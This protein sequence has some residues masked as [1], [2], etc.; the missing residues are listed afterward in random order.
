MWHYIQIQRPNLIFL[1][2]ILKPYI[3]LNSITLS[4]VAKDLHSVARLLVDQFTYFGDRSGRT[5]WGM[6]CLRPLKHWGRRFESHLRH[7]CVCMFILC[8]GL[9]T[10]WSPVEEV[11]PTVHRIKKLKKGPRP[12]KRAVEQ[13][14]IIIIII[15]IYFGIISIF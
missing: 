10:S 8:C 14:I 6:N 15:I 3:K 13:L 5:V 4:S 11:L 2:E 7:G 9:A 1:H 12:N